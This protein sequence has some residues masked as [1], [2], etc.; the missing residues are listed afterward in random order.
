[1]RVGILGAGTI[2]RWAHIPGY[3]KLADVEVVAVAD[4]RPARAAETAARFSIPV[5]F[6]DY[7]ELLK[8]DLDAVSVCLPN[9]LHSEAVLASIAAG[10]HVLCE[11]SMAMT[12]AEAE[13][14]VKA[15]RAAGKLL[16][17]GFNNRYR[18]DARAVRR[19]VQAGELGE[20][21]YARSGWMRRRG[22][23]G[24]GSWFTRKEQSGGGTLIDIGVHA[25]DLTMW[26]MGMPKPVAVMGATF[27]HFGNRPGRGRGGW[28]F[29]E[30]S[31][32]FDVDDLACAMIRFENG[33]TL[34][35]EASWAA[36]VERE[37]MFINLYGSEAGAQI[38][39]SPP[40]TRVFTEKEGVPHDTVLH[41]PDPVQAGAHH[42][43]IAEFVRCIKEGATPLSPGEDGVT[44]M[45]V[46]EAIYQSASAGGS[47]AI[48]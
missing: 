27:A 21:Y 39:G 29:P 11:K 19:M 22:I 33:S 20:I 34:V 30:P 41:L 47:V 32:Y 23:P 37:Q 8:L 14:M 25:L 9:Y 24:W 17:M 38:A 43:E 16:M 2:A 5:T 46:L 15:A 35:L 45:R 4:I 48:G 40:Q 3:Q 1:M 28:G 31:G 6:S 13:A 18:L 12:V 36:H 7:R 10:C 42:A 26:L 44:V